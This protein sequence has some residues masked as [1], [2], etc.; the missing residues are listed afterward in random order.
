MRSVGAFCWAISL[1]LPAVALATPAA[2]I[3]RVDPETVTSS[4]APVL[5]TIL[6]LSDA[7]RISEVTGHCAGLT[8]TEALNCESDALEAPLALY[9]PYKLPTEQTLLTIRIDGEEFPAKLESVTRFGDTVHEPGIGTAWL[10]VLDADERGKPGFQ[11]LHRVASAFVSAL[12]ATDLVNVVVLGEKQVIGDSGWKTQSGRDAAEAILG[13]TREV[14]KSRDRTRPLLTLLKQT[15][16]D[17]FR[18]LSPPSGMR[19]PL[20]QAVLVLSSGYGGGDPATTGPGAA[21]L[22]RYLTAGRFG[23]VDALLPKLPL[24]TIAI[25]TP[26]TGYAEHAQLASDFMRNLANPEIGGFFS[27]VQKGQ[28]ARAPRIVDAVRARFASL[29]VARFRLACVGSTLTQ[30]LSLIFPGADP[31]VVGDSSFKDVPLGFDPASWPLDVDLATTR[32]EI[33]AAGGLFPGSTFKVFGQFCWGGDLSRP[34]VYFLPPGETLPDSLQTSGSASYEDVRKR[35]IAL[36][37]RS[38]AVA[39][40]EAFAEFR[41]PDTDRI[42]HGSGERQAARF[43]IVDRKA[44]RSSGLTAG[45]AIEVKAMKRPIPKF[46]YWALGGAA[47]LILTL[48][49]FALARLIS[50]RRTALTTYSGIRIE[51]SPYLTP[52]PISQRGPRKDPKPMARVVLHGQSERFTV[53]PDAEL[54]IGRDSSR[55]T[56]V[57]G[58][59]QVSG[60]HATFRI[61]G[62]TL[63]VRDENSHAGTRVRGERIGSGQFVE[64]RDEDTVELG[65]ESLRVEFIRP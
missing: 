17:A 13:R 11:E 10:I 41:V 62:G 16:Q 32:R 9:R 55:V 2:K 33:D 8:G 42:L 50:K 25:M 47:A 5:T 60:V 56:A 39:A 64:V 40:N 21:E 54:T 38:P 49:W 37:M 28:A 43:V 14:V 18:T 23:E 7:R 51:G 59:P 65:P 31:P 30:S 45:T 44:K 36:D 35:L 34:E 3:L 53:L 26:P 61:E 63:L 20:H 22:S 57:L 48:V 12:A 19:L 29:L 4:G 6:D 15:I 58:H 52:A 46:W 24:P 27:V 1:L